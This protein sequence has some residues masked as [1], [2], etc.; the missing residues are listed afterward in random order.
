MLFHLAR[1]SLLAQLA[2][3][4]LVRSVDDAGMHVADQLLRD[5]ARAARIA[6]HGV[7]ESTRD[8]HEIDAVVLVEPLILDGHERLR[9]VLRQR[10]DR[11]ARAPLS[12]DLADER[13]IPRVDQR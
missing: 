10:L 5:G 8:A 9:H 2:T 6:E 7:L 11:D 4:A 3:E 13:A 1:R 12:A